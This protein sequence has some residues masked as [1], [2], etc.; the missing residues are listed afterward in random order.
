M[1]DIAQSWDSP[2]PP[3]LLTSSTSLLPPPVI[4]RST[5]ASVSWLAATQRPGVTQPSSRLIEEY[6]DIVEKTLGC[7]SCVVNNRKI[8]ICNGIPNYFSIEMPSL[9]VLNINFKQT[10]ITVKMS[11]TLK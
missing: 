9:V 5:E 10:D 7:N 4:V 11:L 6:K 1:P 8:Y 3:F 2:P